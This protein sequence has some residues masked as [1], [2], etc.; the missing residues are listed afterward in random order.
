MDGAAAPGLERA[1]T[2]SSVSLPASRSQSQ[3]VVPEMNHKIN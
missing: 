3:C 2:V 1:D